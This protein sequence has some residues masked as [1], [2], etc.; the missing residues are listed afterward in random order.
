MDHSNAYYRDTAVSVWPT[1]VAAGY[2]F[3]FRSQKLMLW[4][5]DSVVHVNVSR[6]YGVSE[7]AT[8]MSL[9]S[10]YC[11]KGTLRLEGGTNLG[12]TKKK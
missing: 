10:E 12:V 8:R 4:M 9:V 11:C 7:D 6:F 3:S 2:D 1:S 5:V